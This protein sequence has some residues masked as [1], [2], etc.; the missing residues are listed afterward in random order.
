VESQFPDWG[1]PQSSGEQDLS[2]R[3]PLPATAI[4]WLTVLCLDQQTGKTLWTKM[5]AV[6]HQE[7]SPPHSGS[8]VTDVEHLI[9]SFSSYGLYC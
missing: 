5:L 2:A 3:R 1:T 6:P 4:T 7:I 8:P 9:V